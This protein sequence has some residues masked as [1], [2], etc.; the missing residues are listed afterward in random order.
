MK[1]SSPPEIFQMDW[2]TPEIQSSDLSD[3]KMRRIELT[4]TADYREHNPAMQ[5]SDCLPKCCYDISPVCKRDCSFFKLWT[6]I[7]AKSMIL[8]TSTYFFSFIVILILIACC[9]LVR[10]FFYVIRILRFAL[11]IFFLHTFFLKI[12]LS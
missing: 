2:N 12:V 1:H 9:Q 11:V 5:A 10:F 7:R 6:I 4:R 8:V 3:S